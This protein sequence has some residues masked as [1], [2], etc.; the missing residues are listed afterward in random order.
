MQ[1]FESVATAAPEESGHAIPGL[2]PRAGARM[3]TPAALPLVPPWRAP[4]DVDTTH[5]VLP[6]KDSVPGQLARAGWLSSQ[7]L[8]HAWTRSLPNAPGIPFAAGVAAREQPSID[9]LLETANAAVTVLANL[10]AT[11]PRGR[12]ATWQAPLQA[13]RTNLGAALA[14]YAGPLANPHA[15]DTAQRIEQVRSA[16]LG[17]LASQHALVADLAPHLGSLAADGALAAPAAQA[18]PDDLF[19]EQR[20]AGP[21]PLLLRGIDTLPAKFPLTHAQ[22]RQVMGDHDD[23][24]AAGAERR[25]YLLDYVDNS[26][27][28]T[29]GPV[30]KPLAGVGYAYAPI[31]LFA[32]PRDGASLVP[33]AIQCDQDPVAHPIFL[34]ADPAN[35]SASAYWAWQ[36]AKTVVQSAD[37]CHHEMFAHLAR[38]HFVSEALCMAMHRNLAATHPLHLLL[39]PHFEG[40]AFINERIARFQLC[41]GGV[42]D[43]LFAA[44]VRTAAQMVLKDRLAFDFRASMLPADLARRGVDDTAALSDYPYRD[45]ALLLWR[46]IER[47]VDDY[48]QAYY[49][50]DQDVAGDHELSAWRDDLA[51]NGKIRGMP[52]LTTRD[53]LIDTLTMVIF[54]ASVQHAAVS[55]PQ[56]SFATCAPSQAGWLAAP[57][58]GAGTDATQARWR[59]MLPSPLTTLARS[60]FAQLTGS[61]RYR[62]LGQYL[63][64]DFPHRPLLTDPRIVGAGGPLDRFRSALARIET[65]IAA[66]NL[67]RRRPYPFLLPSR[68]A[69]STHI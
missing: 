4:P 6:Q 19:A 51:N 58:P 26:L 20:V 8:T 49:L 47:W 36:M 50:T 61:V 5:P 21:N 69:P 15:P 45:D 41:P 11:L 14:A 27:L 48:V 53:A 40:T 55:A 42:D 38:T 10:L 64:A 31:A 68:I 12:A 29:A 22:Y 34:R 32:V 13:I 62:R 9:W 46:A 39:A 66:R 35:T 67:M 7:R 52:A 2:A 23:L 24:V 44:P 59:A 16:L 17:V 37:A 57:A 1:R 54:T 25:L 33:V 63:S 28:A 30:A 60:A 56:P 43:L 18:C 65:T 3:P